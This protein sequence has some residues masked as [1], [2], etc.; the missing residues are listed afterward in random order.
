MMDESRLTKEILFLNSMRESIDRRQK[1][2]E[3]E[4][5]NDN[6]IHDVGFEFEYQNERWQ[7]TALEIAR[8]L[9]NIEVRYVCRRKL[10]TGNLSSTTHNLYRDHFTIEGWVKP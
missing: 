1:D 3:A 7:I 9:E 5:I 4:Y 6:K 10:K 8:G 2:L